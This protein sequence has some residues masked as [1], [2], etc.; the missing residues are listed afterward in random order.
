MG[1]SG[2]AIPWFRVAMYAYVGLVLVFIM[3]P[4]ATMVLYSFHS[5]TFPKFPPDGFTLRWYR[6][7]LEDDAFRQAA[8][9]SLQVGVVAAALSTLLGACTAIYFWRGTRFE[10]LYTVLAMVPAITP[11]TVIG[12]GALILYSRLG[13]SGSL[14]TVGL[15]H[16]GLTAVFSAFIIRMRLNYVERSVVDAARNLGASELRIFG[17]ILLP[18]MW[19]AMLASFVVALAVSFEEVILARYLTF[20]DTTL[21]VFILDKIGGS[22]NPSLNAMASL[23]VAAVL[24]VVAVVSAITVIR[25]PRK[26]GIPT[27]PGR[28]E[29]DI[30]S[31]WDHDSSIQRERGADLGA[32]ASAEG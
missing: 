6:L 3:L 15:A 12:V 14:W 19:P 1:R 17:G 27:G 23:T 30:F 10:Q 9:N 2:R 5:L 4:I 28:L 26:L 20:T 22:Y 18:L 8:R 16:A 32:V 13:F 25:P 29:G 24:L 11:T 7:A 31:S 21:P